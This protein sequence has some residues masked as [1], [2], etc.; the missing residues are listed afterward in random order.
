MVRKR[1]QRNHRDAEELRMLGVELYVKWLDVGPT[2]A[3]DWPEYTRSVTRI[4]T[5]DLDRKSD[6]ILIEIHN[7]P[8][9][10][11]A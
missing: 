1:V 8:K 5:G 10:E 3:V 9:K 4:T 7:G 2:Y 6:C 11:V